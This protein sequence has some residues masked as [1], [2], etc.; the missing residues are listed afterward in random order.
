MRIGSTRWWKSQVLL[1]LSSE[2]LR[3]SELL[4]RVSSGPT[5]GQR[6]GPATLF[7]I[8]DQLTRDGQVAIGTDEHAQGRERRT[9]RLTERG[10]RVR[11]EAAAPAV[12]SRSR[13]MARSRPVPSFS[14][15]FR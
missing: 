12:L 14:G 2:P 4:Q 15:G 9:F 13:S 11:D 10:R 8:L 1:A 6:L 7:G 5:R 3:A